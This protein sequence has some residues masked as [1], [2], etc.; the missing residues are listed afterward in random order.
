MSSSGGGISSFIG[1]KW[2]AVLAVVAIAAGAA[3]IPAVTGTP[4]GC[5]TSTANVPDG[6]DPW[7]GC[8]PGPS[9]TGPNATEASMSAYSGPCTITAAN[10]TID[11]KVVNCST[12]DIESTA[13]GLMIKNSYLK[14]GVISFD[15]ATFTVQDS[16]LDNAISYPACTAP[17]SCSAGL[18]ACGDPN[19]GTTECGVGYRNYTLVRTEIVNTNRAAYCESTCTIQDNYFHG[20][21]QWPDHTNLAHASSVRNEQN[22]TLTHNSLA[23]DFPGE[24][25]A[26]ELGCSADMSGY[27]DFAPIKNDTIHRNLF[28][29]NNTGAAYCVYGGA[30]SGKP[31]SADATNA[32]NIVFTQNVFKKG[33]NGK[34]GE[35]GHVTDFN[36][37]RTGNVWSGNV[38]DDGTTAASD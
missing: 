15:G 7:G 26:P 32:T 33:A 13:N 20:T 14:G 23:C 24:A 31:F 36:P 19:N 1:S 11:S 17:S 22:M 21:N 4:G 10:V 35:F 28:G 8:F 2:G 18:Y 25:T 6:P 30:T 12:L 5:A 34:C 16:Y 38:F 29:S 9:N 37:A 27:P 3:T